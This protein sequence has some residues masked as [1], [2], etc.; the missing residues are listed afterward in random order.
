[1]YI[2]KNYFV[3]KTWASFTLVQEE[4]LILFIFH[5]KFLFLFSTLKRKM[6]PKDLD[7]SL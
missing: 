2:L 4:T 3:E 7:M 1:M 6:D 5:R